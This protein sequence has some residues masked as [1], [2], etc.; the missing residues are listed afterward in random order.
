M[1]KVLS[2]IYLCFDICVLLLL[3]VFKEWLFVLL[4]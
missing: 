2:V 1:N 4:D 3:L